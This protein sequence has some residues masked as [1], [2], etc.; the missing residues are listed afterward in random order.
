MVLTPLADLKTMIG[1]AVDLA[2]V[3]D[4][5]TGSWNSRSDDMA[6]TSSLGIILSMSAE[7]T[8][9]FDGDTW[10][11]GV[12]TISLSA[13]PNLIGLPV[14]APNVTNVST[15]AGLFAANVVST[16]VVSTDDGF[17]SVGA[18]GDAGDGPVMGDAAYLV[19][20]KCCWK[21]LSSSV[22]VGLTVLAQALRQSRSLGTML[23]IRHL[24]LMSMVPSLMKSPDSQEKDS[25][26][27]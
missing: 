8:V 11:G 15:I 13:G 1:D 9:T 12:S 18:A 14:N 16:V 10:D 7:A 26:S 23:T 25:V 3:Y 2:I 20:G 27:R 19:N 6:I 5:A 24:S 4:S 22:T 21:T 17:K